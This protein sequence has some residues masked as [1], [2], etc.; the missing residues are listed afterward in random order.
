MSEPAHQDHRDAGLVVA[1]VFRFRP[2]FVGLVLVQDR[3][4]VADEAEAG[5]GGDGE[6]GDARIEEADEPADGIA[7]DAGQVA[8]AEEE[9]VT[10]DAAHAGLRFGAH[11]EVLQ[12]AIA[13][14]VGAQ[15]VELGLGLLAVPILTRVLMV[16]EDLGVDESDQTL[17]QVGRGDV[18]G[19]SLRAVD[20]LQLQQTVVGQAVRQWI[21]PQKAGADQPLQR[22]AEVGVVA[23]DRGGQQFDR[24]CRTAAVRRR[25]GAQDIGVL[26]GKDVQFSHGQAPVRRKRARPGGPRRSGW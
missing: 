26:D 3:V 23:A 14:D 20:R 22:F 17:G 5:G 6:N 4:L 18:R 25:D 2:G 10:D 24:G 8:R 15:G 19:L 13:D 1:A 7:G 21:G 16:G 11:D 9:P 12:Q